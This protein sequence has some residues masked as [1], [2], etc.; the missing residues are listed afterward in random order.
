[1][2]APHDT[3]VPRA[4]R[5]AERL[6]E[7]LGLTIEAG[8]HII[9]RRGDEVVTDY[10]AGDGRWGWW[11]VEDVLRDI[12]RERVTTE[13]ATAADAYRAATTTLAEAE[14]AA[15]AA[16]RAA[17]A[18]RKRHAEAAAALLAARE[19]L[20][21]ADAALPDARARMA[22]VALSEVLA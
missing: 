5:H 2:T 20:H 11:G 22:L 6:A 14:A 7:A 13:A 1:M 16:E 10:P 15:V 9:V 3:S 12:A 8:A 4:R 19:S 18:A 21:R 17:E